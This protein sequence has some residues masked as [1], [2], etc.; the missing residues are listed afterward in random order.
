MRTHQAQLFDLISIFS[1]SLLIN[2]QFSNWTDKRECTA[3]PERVRDGVPP[4]SNLGVGGSNPSE[5]TN[6]I[7]DLCRIGLR[8]LLTG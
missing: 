6:K 2:T 7:K 5:R 3:S 1:K 4:V 8:I